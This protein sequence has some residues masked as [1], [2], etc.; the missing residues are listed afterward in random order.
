[1]FAVGNLRPEWIMAGPGDV[2][3]ESQESFISLLIKW[4]FASSP[5]LWE[6]WV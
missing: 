3:E 1:M 6:D 5:R 2:Q 4:V